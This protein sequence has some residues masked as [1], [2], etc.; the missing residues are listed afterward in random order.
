MVEG[1]DD[2]EADAWERGE[3]EVEGGDFVGCRRRGGPLVRPGEVIGRGSGVE[4][5]ASAGTHALRCVLQA[6]VE[7]ICLGCWKLTEGRVAEG[8][9]EGKVKGKPGFPAM[10][11]TEEEGEANWEEGG[12]ETLCFR[13]VS[14]VGG[15]K[16]CE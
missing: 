7:Y 5:F 14:V 10:G 3:P 1:V 2:E 12:D 6:E 16:V 11:L 9:G 8:G 13:L 4:K 15:K